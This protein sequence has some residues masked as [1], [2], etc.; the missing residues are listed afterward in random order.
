MK[1]ISYCLLPAS[2]ADAAA[3]VGDPPPQG[4]EFF[5]FSR[6]R[7]GIRRTMGGHA[8][9]LPPQTR[10]DSAKIADAVEVAA[11]GEYPG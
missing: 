3:V 2:A 4:G 1:L 8:Q 9:D 11:C 6:R 5:P 7:G 10:R